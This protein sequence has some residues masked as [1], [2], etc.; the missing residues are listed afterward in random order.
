MAAL[1]RDETTVARLRAKV[2][3]IRDQLAS[4]L[5][6][7][8]RAAELGERQG[9]QLEA[10]LRDNSELRRQLEEAYTDLAR[11]RDALATER[12]ERA[13]TREKCA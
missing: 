6:A 11:A 3:K 5:E 12:A 10:L 2:R 9:L 8:E 1:S 13:A 7:R 4:S